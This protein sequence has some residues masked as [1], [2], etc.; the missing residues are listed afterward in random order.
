MARARLGNR[1]KWSKAWQDGDR[2]AW[3]KNGILMLCVKSALRGYGQDAVWKTIPSKSGQQPLWLVQNVKEHK[4]LRRH[5]KEQVFGHPRDQAVLLPA[6]CYRHTQHFYLD[7]EGARQC[8]YCGLESACRVR[9]EIVECPRMLRHLHNVLGKILQHLRKDVR[10]DV[11]LRTA[12][13]GVVLR[14][15]SRVVYVAWL[16]REQ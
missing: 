13:K 2:L 3:H 6:A 12:W 8:E 9:Q 1:W 16:G 14:M 10:H 15:G 7:S 4:S 5:W 11:I